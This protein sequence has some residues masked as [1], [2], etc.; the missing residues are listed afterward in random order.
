MRGESTES[1]N[2]SNGHVSKYSVKGESE[3]DGRKSKE[4]RRGVKGKP[5]QDLLNESHNAI[6]S[7]FRHD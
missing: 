7:S 5:Y 4:G 2:E 6:S 1:R 3:G